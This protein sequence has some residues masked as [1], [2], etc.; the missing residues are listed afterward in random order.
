[1]VGQLLSCYALICIV[2]ETTVLCN[3]GLLQS[4]T[5][6]VE[7]GWCLWRGAMTVV[8]SQIAA[9]EMAKEIGT[10][11]DPYDS[12]QACIDAVSLCSHCETLSFALPAVLVLSP[13]YV[14]CSGPRAIARE[15]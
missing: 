6:D 12:T 2:T 7:H 3:A 9:H 8:E 13:P 5:L 11:G 4:L 14:I 10:R 1:M 15:K